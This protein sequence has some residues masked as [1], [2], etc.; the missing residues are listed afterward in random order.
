MLTPDWDL[1]RNYSIVV[2]AL[3][4]DYITIDR[5]MIEYWHK[6]P[7]F[8]CSYQLNLLI[9]AI[10]NIPYRYCKIPQYPFD[11]KYQKEEKKE[12]KEKETV[13]I[14]TTTTTTTVP[15]PESSSITLKGKLGNKLKQQMN[16]AQKKKFTT[17]TTAI[18]E[19]PNQGEEASKISPIVAGTLLCSLH[20]HVVDGSWFVPLG[21]VVKRRMCHLFSKLLNVRCNGREFPDL[22]LRYM[23]HF[24]STYY[25]IHQLILISLLGNYPHVQ[26]Q[27]TPEIENRSLLY[28][29]FASPNIK[30]W[31]FDVTT[32]CELFTMN[33]MRDF[34]IYSVSTHPALYLQI[35]GFLQW[36]DFTTIIQS[37]MNRI[38]IY[39]DR[40]LGISTSALIGSFGDP[41][42]SYTVY[43]KKRLY[44]DLNYILQPSRDSILGITFSRD[45]FDFEKYLRS[46]LR[47]CEFVPLK[48]GGGDLSSSSKTWKEIATTIKPIQQKEEEEEEE[49]DDEE[50][51]SEKE[52]FKLPKELESMREVL[53][54]FG[55]ST[56]PIDK[57]T[58]DFNAIIPPQA[59]EALKEIIARLDPTSPRL[60][61][62]C[63]EYLPCFGIDDE[64]ILYI[65]LL[66]N[67]YEYGT[68][69][70]SRIQI[71]LRAL[72]YCEPYAYN[73]IQL[74]SYF[75][76]EARKHYYWIQLPHHITLA[77]IK[78]C[79]SR[80]PH[81]K[82]TRYII[83][84]TAHLVYCSVCLYKYSLIEVFPNKITKH[85]GFKQTYSY[86][87]R[88]AKVEYATDKIY[89]TKNKI[90]NRGNCNNQEL[91]KI[92][93]LGRLI[94]F[95]KKGYMNCTRCGK[96]MLLD[97]SQCAML[98][99]G[100]CCYTCTTE[101]QKNE[102]PVLE[103]KEKLCAYCNCLLLTPH[104]TH[105]Y[106][107]GLYLCKK[108]HSH[109]LVKW[110]QVTDNILDM[111]S[112]L[113]EKIQQLKQDYQ[114]KNKVKDEKL[115]K[116]H[117]ALYNNN[118]SRRK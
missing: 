114:E 2:E 101:I 33:A 23:Q 56:T 17:I 95:G 92:F 110:V 74:I 73:L 18:I 31:L 106:P 111:K 98:E 43:C 88:N 53:M 19:E 38:R 100:P 90:N 45:D 66:F 6:N 69:A 54:D 104:S 24:P 4:E 89:C 112:F 25:H 107:N 35:K 29:Y 64:T 70:K 46:V 28:E 68:L 50:E 83:P 49:G 67:H 97:L 62:R 71:K 42:L 79:Q 37:N 117:K 75:G 22:C 27:Y 41:T 99:S 61:L 59:L 1:L 21:K 52:E 12:K 82:D 109:Q 63:L 10:R 108:H 103:E 7:E 39:F 44:F 47:I 40:M 26:A 91:S 84:S 48:R 51:D 58:I 32:H 81:T 115:L 60:L 76:D 78:A 15:N 87:L 80:F 77:Q 8:P 57:R 85:K 16:R 102:I 105:M 94:Y 96:L 3:E 11:L 14:I 13:K 5:R 118:N 20:R 116:L 30:Q 65:Y 55:K 86:G 34:L 113:C 9:D 72:Q 36:D 93:T